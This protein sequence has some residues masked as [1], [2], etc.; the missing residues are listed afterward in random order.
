MVRHEAGFT[1]IELMIV[2]AIVGVIAGVAVPNLVSSRATANERAIVA[3]LRTI[4]TAQA[5]CSSQ[6]VVDLDHDG[7]GEALGLGEMAGATELRGGAVR[8]V[9][10]GLAQS[11]GTLDANGFATAKGY[12]LALYLPDATGTGVVA[13]PANDG[14]VDPDQAEI[15]WTC[16]AWPLTR[17]RT[18]SST[19][20]VNQS[21]EIL[22]AR[23]AAYSGRTNV[24]PAGAALVGVPVTSVLG[25]PLAADATGADGNQWR[26]LR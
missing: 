6:Q 7:C 26:T 9:P 13:A 22:V 2:T 19:F 21:G 12:L 25:G 20:F 16:L 11:L 4:A 23:D 10:P 17:G 1:L 18:G 5:Q 3:T 24:P 14:S 8:L 15:A